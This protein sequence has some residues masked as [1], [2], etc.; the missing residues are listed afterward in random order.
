[1]DF[2]P[3]QGTL[4]KELGLEEFADKRGGTM[5]ILQE[6][7]GQRFYK[8]DALILLGKSLGQPWA[9]LANCF[10]V[11]PK[12][13]RDAMYDFVAKNRYLIAGKNDACGLPDERL[14]ERM[15]D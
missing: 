15:R 6:S 8:G 12:A 13:L 11:F 5:V 1:V 4:S 3:L 2:A 14:R 7:D 10:A 9:I